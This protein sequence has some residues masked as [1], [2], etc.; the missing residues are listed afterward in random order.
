VNID[1]RT[2]IA[3]NGDC[4]R[5]NHPTQWFQVSAPGDRIEV[6]TLCSLAHRDAMRAGADE[7]WADALVQRLRR[8]TEPY[9]P[10]NGDN[11]DG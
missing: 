8:E 11:T 4:T 7:A 6:C 3:P 1:D 10:P 2:M 9:D 5:L